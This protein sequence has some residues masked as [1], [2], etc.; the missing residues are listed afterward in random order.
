[1]VYF[2]VRDLAMRRAVENEFLKEHEVRGNE[3]TLMEERH[4]RERLA[5]AGLP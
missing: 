3:R 1:V 5:K 2:P 4:R